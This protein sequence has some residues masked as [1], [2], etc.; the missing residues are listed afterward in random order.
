MFVGFNWRLGCQIP[1]KSFQCASIPEE[2]CIAGV[3]TAKSNLFNL[4]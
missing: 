4:V 3:L 2:F 1:S